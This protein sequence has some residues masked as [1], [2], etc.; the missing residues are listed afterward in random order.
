MQVSGDANENQLL[1]AASAYMD[2]PPMLKNVLHEIFF[3][4]RNE[5]FN[6][7]KECLNTVIQ[8]MDRHLKDDSIQTTG[9]YVNKFPY[10]FFIS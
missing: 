10:S 2:R 9:R 5:M 3:I 4:L 1:V 8:I 7:W 6:D